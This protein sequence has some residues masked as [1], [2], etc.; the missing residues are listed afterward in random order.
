MHYSARSVS[1]DAL[2]RRLGFNPSS[3]VTASTGQHSCLFA[4]MQV[5]DR[6]RIAKFQSL[7][8]SHGSAS[9]STRRAAPVLR[10]DARRTT[11]RCRCTCR[12]RAHDSDSPPACARPARCG[13]Q[14][15][16]PSLALPPRR[17]GA[18][19]APL[20]FVVSLESRACAPPRARCRALAEV[21]V[22]TCTVCAV[23]SGSGAFALPRSSSRA[24]CPAGCR[25][26][27][28]TSPPSAPTLRGHRR[29]P[30]ASPCV[31][32]ARGAR[33]SSSSPS[34]HSRARARRRT[35]HSSLRGTARAAARPGASRATGVRR[36]LCRVALIASAACLR[37]ALLWRRCEHSV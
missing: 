13:S 17:C 23:R 33:V 24:P 34:L 10:E 21:A 16:T 12:T 35:S 18:T 25:P 29:R 5:N 2:S 32:A 3:S 36:V 28:S 20:A 27:S 8:P 15:A 37:G 4:V 22:C 1:H 31:A 26:R 30:S 11:R 9:L 14:S 7:E 6:G 19:A